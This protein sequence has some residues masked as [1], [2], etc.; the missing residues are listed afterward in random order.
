MRQVLEDEMKQCLT[1]AK[2]AELEAKSILRA[3]A[4]D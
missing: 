1:N 3:R 2:D 4:R